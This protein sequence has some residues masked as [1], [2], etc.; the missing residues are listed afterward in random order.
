M[1]E[2]LD[3]AQGDRWGLYNGD[4]IDVMQQLP[5]ESVGYSV[6]SPPFASLYTYSNSDR[7]LGNCRDHQDFF[8]HFAFVLEGLKRII[9]PG[10]LISMHCMDMPL[11]K[12][13]HGVIG[14]WDFPGL[15]IAAAERAGFVFHSRVCIW[16]D[17]VVAMQRTKAIGLLY[18]QVR[19]DSALSRQGFA[20]YIVTLRD[21]RDNGEPIAKDEDAFP[22]G[23]WQ[24][25]ASP[26]WM[27]IDQSDTLQYRAARDGNDER[28]IAPLQLGVIRRCVDLWSNPGDIV[29]SP[30]AGIGSE[31]Y[32]AAE[33]GR[34]GLGAELKPSYFN[35]AVK[36]LQSLQ[37]ATVSIVDEPVS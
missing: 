37:H 32:V 8:D 29:F 27:D 35:Q 36:N 23:L 10:R 17:P 7:D 12:T 26:V 19:K 16:K 14:A 34:F 1:I 25:Y 11:T 4:C 21:P 13:S 2:A 18:K 22:V 28:H 33:M 31:P 30:F 3:F 24:R 5:A 15:L 20:D 9:K 6:F